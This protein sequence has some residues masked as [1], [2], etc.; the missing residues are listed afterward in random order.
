MSALPASDRIPTERLTL[1]L[2]RDVTQ[3]CSITID[4]PIEFESWRPTKQ[5]RFL[6]D[7]IERRLTNDYG[8]THEFDVDPSTAH[9][10]RIVTAARGAGQR[11][12]LENVPLTL[13]LHCGAREK[14]RL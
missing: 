13:E 6:R 4:I 5:E 14:R 10:L 9:G 7:A 11:P 2:A 3:H 8:E 1:I 12:L